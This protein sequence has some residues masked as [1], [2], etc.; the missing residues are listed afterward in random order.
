M[1]IAEKAKEIRIKLNEIAVNNDWKFLVLFDE[2]LTAL[3]EPEEQTEPDY[4][5]MWILQEVFDEIYDS[6]TVSVAVALNIIDNRITKLKSVAS[7]E[8]I[9]DKEIT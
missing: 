7:L 6:N 8:T 4:K 5:Q 2:L 1:T 9:D 3:S